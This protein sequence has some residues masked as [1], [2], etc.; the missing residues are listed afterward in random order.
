MRYELYVASEAPREGYGQ[1][2][3]R[4]LLVAAA[5]HMYVSRPSSD[6]TRRSLNITWPPNAHAP[7][8]REAYGKEPKCTRQDPPILIHEHKT[9]I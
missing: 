8:S 5:A 3:R 9:S 7:R 4:I 6:T 1:T 2:F